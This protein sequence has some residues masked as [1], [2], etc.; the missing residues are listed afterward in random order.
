MSSDHTVTSSVEVATDPATAFAVFTEEIDCW[1]RQG[2]INFH[3]TSRTYAKRIEPG[4]GG[5]VMEVYDPA[6]GDGLELG[7]VTVWEPGVRL[8]WHSSIDDVAIDVRFAASPDDAGRTV[9]RVDATVPAGGADRG[10]SSWVRMTPEWLGRWVD[11][12]DHVAHEPERL[13]RLAIGLHYAKPVTAAHWLHDVFGL[14]T[15]GD[16]PADESEY[17][18]VELRAG[19]ALVLLFPLDGDG[20][21]APTEGEHNAVTHVPW[22]FV[23]DLD[24][25]LAHA[26]AGG[27]TLVGD[28]HDHGFRSYDATD[29]EG[30]RWTFVQA[31]PLMRQR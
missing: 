6:T 20:E 1:W 12:R 29:L 28:I 3:D 31:S 10:G 19:N 18:W 23:D 4:V 9:V 2:P 27:A 30:H 25:H 14:E 13:A 15:T 5:R 21:G 8:A 17:L 22:V 11:R 24:A 26:R 16:L 7:R